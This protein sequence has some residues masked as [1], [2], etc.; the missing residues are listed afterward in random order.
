MVSVTRKGDFIYNSGIG[1]VNIITDGD[2]LAT[3]GDKTILAEAATATVTIS[4]PSVPTEAKELRIKCIDATFA[5]A[6]ERN[7]NL[8][9][10]A[11]RNLNLAL[12]VSRILQYT[13]LHGWVI[14]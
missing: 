12:N 3:N 10:G 1:K 6:I 13:A 2:Y 9:D 7:G 5:C 4:L 8:I 14:L 11:A